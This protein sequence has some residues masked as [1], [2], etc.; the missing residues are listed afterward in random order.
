MYHYVYRITNVKESTHYYGCR[1]SKV[2]PSSDLG[3]NYFSSSSNKEF[4]KDQKINPSNYKYKIIK[5]FTFRSDAEVYESI[6]HER[7]QV[8]FNE[9]FY[10]K[11]KNN[12][13]SLCSTSRKI[14]KEHIIK[15]LGSM[16]DNELSPEHRESI[17]RSIKKKYQDKE[18]YQRFCQIMTEVNRREDKRKSSSKKI[19]D[20]WRDPEYLKKMEKRR[21]KISRKIEVQYPC[22]KKYVYS[23]IG[24]MIEELKLNRRMVR[25]F[26]NTCLPCSTQQ[27]VLTERTKNT[28]GLVFREIKNED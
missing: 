10:N 28:I 22:G 17:R 3:I 26:L 11:T 24:Q 21:E 6:L 19:K 1:T 23:G 4:I 7:F 14:G 20:K 5:E 9:F 15:R 13:M 12:L 18:F 2:T 8:H 25:R 16:K 27:K